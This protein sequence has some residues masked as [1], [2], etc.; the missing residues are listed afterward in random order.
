[1]KDKQLVKTVTLGIVEGDWPRG[2][3]A[4]WSSDNMDSE[5][6]GTGWV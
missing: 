2:K 5:K 1:M 4:R 3:P 6:W